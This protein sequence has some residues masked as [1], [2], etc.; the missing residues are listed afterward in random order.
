MN[1][2]R[3]YILI[4]EDSRTQADM[5]CYLLN[6][7]GYETGV[8]ESG[9]AALVA[10]RQRMPDLILTDI[11]MPGMDG[12][13]LCSAIRSDPAIAHLPVILVTQLY[14]P[15]DV[16]RGISCGANNFI[17]KPYDSTGLLAGIDAVLHP[18]KT[19]ADEKGSI[20]IQYKG[21]QYTVRSDRNDILNILLSIYGTAVTK[22]VELEQATDRLNVLTG[23]LEELVVD[24]TVALQRTTDTVEHL[25][26]QKNELITKI[27]HDLKTPLTP[28]VALL[29]HV[30]KHEQDSE[31]KEILD[32]L[33]NDV[34]VLKGLVEE[35]LK[36]S[37]L[38]QE[39]FSME[40]AD[41]SLS[42]VVHEVIDGY[43][44][45]IRQFNLLVH[46]HIPSE[47][48]AHISPFHVTTIFDNL[49]SNA[50]K[51][52]IRG[53]TITCRVFDEG[54]FWAVTIADTGIGLTQDEANRVFEEFYKADPSRHD[55]SSHGLGLSIVQRIVMFYGGSITV[56]S[57]GKGKGT[58]FQVRLP[59]TVIQ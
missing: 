44:F 15:E 57:P 37:H 31:L 51:Y 43:A 26:M 36:L 42:R 35:I 20:N 24:R 38:N 2:T 39:S 19:P 32:V 13:E 4:A 28:L 29:P 25:L 54:E 34:N 21:N 48:V 18:R 45:S 16:I 59:K 47:C 12:Y 6:Q 41:I 22:N 49:I 11:V 10:V 40:T 50:I 46:N 27:G 33:V 30:L 14:D 56:S 23:S 17:I 53:G 9:T 5:L 52:N 58:T 8:V 7:A 1:D 55:H 3:R